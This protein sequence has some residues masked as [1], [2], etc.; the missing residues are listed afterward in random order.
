MKKEGVWTWTDCAP[1]ELKVWGPNQPDNAGSKRNE[2]C[3]EYSTKYYPWNDGSCSHEAG[4][5]CSKKLCPTNSD[6]NTGSIPHKSDLY[7]TL[8][9]DYIQ[10]RTALQQQRMLPLTTTMVNTKM[11]CLTSVRVHFRVLSSPCAESAR[12]V[13]GRRCPHSGKGKAL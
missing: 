4:F 13:T 6:I 5:L 3:L 10:E 1:W 8:S 7:C 2:D 9:L 11:S 12:A